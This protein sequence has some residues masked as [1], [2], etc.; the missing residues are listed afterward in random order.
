M[1]EEVCA[2]ALYQERGLCFMLS[3]LVRKFNM[4]DID[5]CAI[6]QEML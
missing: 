2:K 6:G 3:T 1:D 5:V 4:Q